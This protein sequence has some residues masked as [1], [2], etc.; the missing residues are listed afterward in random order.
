[1]SEARGGLPAQAGQRLHPVSFLF[2]LLNQLRQLLLVLIGGAW[3]GS[4]DRYEWL[5][6]YALLIGGGLLLVHTLVRVLTTR[7]WVLAEELVVREGV[8]FRRVRHIPYLRVQ[9]VRLLQN[10][11][12]RLTGMTT[13]RL[14]TGSGTGADADLR[15]LPLAEAR[16]IETAV[17]T[18]R[19]EVVAAV[20]PDVSAPPLLRLPLREVLL[21][22][23][24]LD[25]GFLIIAAGL[26]GLFQFDVPLFDPQEW[27]AWAVRGA[28]ALAGGLNLVSL[29][30]LVLGMMLLVKLLTLI[31][32]MLQA[33]L[34]WQGF[35]L[36]QEGSRLRTESGLFTRIRASATLV[37]VQIVSI[38]DGLWFRW[39]DRR[40][41][42][43]SVSGASVALNAERGLDWLAPIARPAVVPALVQVA[44]PGLALA[45]VQWQP[46]AASTRR[47]LA[48]RNALWCL[49]LGM[50]VG[51]L[52]PGLLPMVGV[53][54][55]W[56]QLHAAL[57]AR[58]AGWALH[59][60][61]LLW[62]S[63]VGQRLTWA[64]PVARMAGLR[65]SQSP[66]DRRHAT[67]SLTLDTQAPQRAHRLRL[68]YLHLQDAA[69]LARQLRPAMLDPA[70]H[71][72][73]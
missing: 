35:V 4:Q 19:N 73:G 28:M 30:L 54:A 40:A 27:L 36:E 47:R 48:R 60:G 31:L 1:M 15:V 13:L 29:A 49:V 17:R 53:L 25:R 20:D 37:R 45:T 56:G 3:A 67:A 41:V 12:H 6:T 16:R 38:Y 55:I 70:T 72:H 52:K 7:Y 65:L 71:E 50:G 26:V 44:L 51:W 46:V 62:R 34:L 58:Y 32:S 5:F 14:E 9:N 57:W 33:L 2:E 59:E 8:I 10:P 23:V 63:G 24:V 11:L 21:A 61:H 64:I 22:G 39:L 18:Q 43:V 66:F 69:T 42:S 68:S